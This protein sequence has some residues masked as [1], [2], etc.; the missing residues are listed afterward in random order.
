M[1]IGYHG[2]HC[3]NLIPCVMPVCK[4][5]CSLASWMVVPQSCPSL[6][7][8]SWGEW[9]CLWNC[10][11]QHLS[12]SCVSERTVRVHGVHPLNRLGLDKDT[13]KPLGFK[14]AI[15]SKLPFGKPWAISL[16]SH[17]QQV[18][19]FPIDGIQVLPLLKG[20]WF[21]SEFHCCLWICY[22]SNGFFL[23]VCI[24]SF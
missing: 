14:I 3:G 5:P 10:L 2:R 21:C 13:W 8:G 9:G 18:F 7:A 23:C 19:N 12:S 16:K 1:V 24:R 17:S 20:V 4:H 6:W 22:F 15:Q 11:T